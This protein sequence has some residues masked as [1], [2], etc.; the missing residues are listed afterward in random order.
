MRG[1]SRH[2]DAATI[3]T[4]TQIPHFTSCTGGQAIDLFIGHVALSPQSQTNLIERDVLPS[5]ISRYVDH[6]I[7]VDARTKLC[8]D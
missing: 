1:S 6:Q 8:V 4:K 5:Q 2:V 3:N 7:A